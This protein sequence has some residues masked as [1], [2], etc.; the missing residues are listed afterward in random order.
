MKKMYTVRD[1]VSQIGK[2]LDFKNYLNINYMPRGKSRCCPCPGSSTPTPSP[3][4]PRIVGS[5]PLQRTGVRSDDRIASQRYDPYYADYFDRKARE[6]RTAQALGM[7][8][9]RVQQPG[10]RPV[11][12][13]PDVLD[14]IESYA[15]KSGGKRT[16]KYKRRPTKKKTNKKKKRTN[17]RKTNKRKSNRRK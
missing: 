15:N 14:I 11:Y 16:R 1:V 2:N 9:R 13:A 5:H 12:P 7:I 17:R 3:E 4:S 8:S 6:A 10:S